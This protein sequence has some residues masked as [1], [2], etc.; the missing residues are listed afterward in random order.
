MSF[1]AP[2]CGLK[3][4]RIFWC[5]RWPAASFSL[6]PPTGGQVPWGSSHTQTPV[7]EKAWNSLGLARTVFFV[8]QAYKMA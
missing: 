7:D 5:V 6:S 8:A 3:N 1:R 2:Y 4:F